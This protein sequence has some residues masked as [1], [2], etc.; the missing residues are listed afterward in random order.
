MSQYNQ[1]PST[2]VMAYPVPEPQ[3]VGQLRFQVANQS[4]TTFV[5]ACSP[6]DCVTVYHGEE[7]FHLQGL[8]SVL[9]V[10]G[11]ISYSI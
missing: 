2:V 7:V 11:I 10:S 8:Y 4:S 9:N 5:G 1:P 3:S 6:K